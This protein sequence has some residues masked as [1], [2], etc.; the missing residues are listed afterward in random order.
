MAE[1]LY[2]D[3]IGERR[4]ALVERG[5]IIAARIDWDEAG[6][7]AGA[8]LPGR[9]AEVHAG[10]RRGLVRLDG[11]GEALLEPIGRGVTEGAA[12]LIEIV[13]EAI[14]EAGRP[15]PAR[16][17]LGE[18][19]A[20][21]APTLREALEA[22][23]HPVRA[24]L[25]HQPDA[26]EAAGW[27]EL[28]S[29][30]LTGEIAF[31]GGGLRLSPTPAMTLFDVDGG[32]PPFE[33]ARAGAAAAVRAILRMDIGGSIGIDLPTLASKA[34][35]HAVADVIDAAL[36]QPFE[37]TAMNGFGF[38]QIVRRRVSASL[39]ERLRADRAGAAAR[40]LLRMAERTPGAGTLTLVAA[41]AVIAAIR[42][43]WTDALAARIGA[44]VAL[45]AEPGRPISALHVQPEHP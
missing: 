23:G 11:G 27:S 30:A 28:L 7:R 33:L 9:L 21:A 1:W 19:P 34:E 18:G 8:V 40:A 3:G 29:E 6:P 25:P 12:V 31:A 10:G 5:E 26:L 17:R 2:E 16:A 4:A 43:E 15:K 24:L 39:P 32:L 36:P 20:R 45:Q 35:R 13:R 41:P 37:R 22:T 14:P 44:P 38:L 42:P